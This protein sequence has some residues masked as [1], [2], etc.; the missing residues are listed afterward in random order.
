MSLVISLIQSWAVQIFF[1]QYCQ[2]EVSKITTRLESKN[3]VKNE[4]SKSIDHDTTPTEIFDLQVDRLVH[5]IETPV[6]FDKSCRVTFKGHQNFVSCLA[7]TPDGKYVVSGSGDSSPKVWD[8][9][10]L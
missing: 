8:L 3:I 9:G 7:I 5:E 4:P 6:G 2:G 1:S 10:A